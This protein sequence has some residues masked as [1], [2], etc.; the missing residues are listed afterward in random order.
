ML[1]FFLC[2]F[3]LF[4]LWRQMQF[5]LDVCQTSLMLPLR[6]LLYSE[7]DLLSVAR[8]VFKTNKQNNRATDLFSQFRHHIFVVVIS[9]C[10]A[11]AVKIKWKASM[12]IHSD[13]YN[14]HSREVLWVDAVTLDTHWGTFGFFFLYI[15]HCQYLGWPPTVLALFLD[16][17]IIIYSFQ[18]GVTSIH[19]DWRVHPD[20]LTHQLWC[21][22]CLL[23]WRCVNSNSNPSALISSCLLQM[24]QWVSKWIPDPENKVESNIFLCLLKLKDRLWNSLQACRR[25]W[26][27]LSVCLPWCHC[28]F[29]FLLVICAETCDM[30]A[31]M[32][33]NPMH[34]GYSLLFLSCLYLTI[35]Y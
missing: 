21:T 7:R 19:T 16:Y 31:K 9:V 3:F 35:V 27:Q 11:F 4:P 17:F 18:S 30:T 12:K 15:F 24:L 22:P 34:I 28:W 1:F 2:T 10:L 20:T 13:R 25:R 29:H 14:T 33:K 8:L 23:A 5:H 26:A 32:K 6:H